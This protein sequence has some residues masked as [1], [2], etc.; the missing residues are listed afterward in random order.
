[1]SRKFDVRKLKEEGFKN[2]LLDL[3]LK[4]YLQIE[5]LV[6]YLNIETGKFYRN[7]DLITIFKRI[8]KINKINFQ[9]LMRNIEA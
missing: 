1:V 4:G 7:R 6:R 9:E 8:T 5:D 3:E 2:E